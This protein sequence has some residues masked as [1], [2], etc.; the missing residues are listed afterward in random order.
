[1]TLVIDM[2]YFWDK[3]SIRA[4][5]SELE[6]RRNKASNI[7]DKRQLEEQI[8][9]A[10]GIY[11]ELI[12]ACMPSTKETIINGINDANNNHPY[13]K[14]LN[15]FIKQTNNFYYNEYNQFANNLSL[16][17][18]SHDDA[19]GLT[20]DFYQSI[21]GIIYEGFLDT[22]NNRYRRIMF[23]KQIDGLGYDVEGVTY[24]ISGLNKNYILLNNCKTVNKLRCLIHE[25]GHVMASYINNQRYFNNFNFFLEVE[26][27]FMEMIAGDFFNKQN[28]G[29]DWKIV[30][31]ERMTSYIEMAAMDVEMFKIN[32][33]AMENNYLNIDELIKDLRNKM[34]EYNLS[35]DMKGLNLT[36]DLVYVMSYIKAINLYQLYLVDPEMAL[37]NLINLIKENTF[38]SE[39]IWQILEQ[40]EV[41][42]YGTNIIKK[43]KLGKE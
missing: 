7:S 34:I 10:K 8:A 11:S 20:N 4:D 12:Y 39:E 28:Q 6:Y 40:Q 3:Q 30:N 16:I 35:K 26:S 19:L 17:R 43:L 9:W 31:C 33:L 15:Y 24:N 41:E 37:N 25:F 1:M 23:T 38:S 2:K 27:I 42:K 29:D 21:G 14:Y 13:L 18:L 32:K 5:I 22:Y 36:E